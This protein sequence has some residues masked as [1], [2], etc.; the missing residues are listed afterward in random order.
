MKSSSKNNLGAILIAIVTGF[1]TY[2]LWPTLTTWFS[3]S[4]NPS[5]QDTLKSAIQSNKI[6]SG[7]HNNQQNQ[8]GNNNVQL[9]IPGTSAKINLNSPTVITNNNNSPSLKNLPAVNNGF[10]NNGGVGNTYQQSILN[11][12]VKPPQRHLDDMELLKIIDSL[13]NKTYSCNIRLWNAD[14][15]SVAFGQEI[16]DK[17]ARVGYHNL[18]SSSFTTFEK[19]PKNKFL[20]ERYY[21]PRDSAVVITIYSQ[22]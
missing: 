12:P 21:S 18:S 17:L 7:S 3:K 14:S 1:F 22:R 19:G 13:P 5:K 20:I 9:N 11:G 4:T 6:D 2:F 8:G 16:A 15:E 10:I